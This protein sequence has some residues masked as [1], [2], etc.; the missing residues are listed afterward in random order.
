M[1]YRIQADDNRLSISLIVSSAELMAINQHD[2][3]RHATRSMAERLVDKL[4]R[5][6][7]ASE[8]GDYRTDM[9]L[10]LNVYA[11]T[12]TELESLIA[13]ARESGRQDAMR[14]IAPPLEQCND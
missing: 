8:V 3:V 10:T 9:L 11:F 1:T 12:R 7:V 5:N 13:D 14:W 6:V 4:M 2:I